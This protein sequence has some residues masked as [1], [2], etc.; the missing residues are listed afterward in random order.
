MDLLHGLLFFGLLIIGNFAGVRSTWFYAIIGIGGVWLAFFFSGV[1][2]TIAGI[3]TAVAIPGRVKIK[4]GTFLKRLD[5]LHKRFQESKS[6]KGTL[7]SNQQLEILEDIKTTS[8][9]AETPLQ[10][11]ERALHPLVSFIILPLFALANAG[12]HLHGD[13]L[14]VL[15]GPVGLGIGL[16]L[17]FGKFI[18]IAA[19]S[20]ILVAL[21]LAKLPENVSWNMIYGT[22]F[23]GGIGF[24]MSL[25]INELAFSDESL[26]F[27]AKV[28]ILFASL[29]SGIVGAILLHKNSKKL[30]TIK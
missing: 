14:K 22:A 1:H 23:L 6:I 20:R 18:G 7:I 5:A 2:P 30:I 25:F 12:I 4:E 13:L 16:G 21:K 17:I 27:A 19:F 26:I 9:E 24:T 10:K 3:L 11:L 8:S 28:S 29:I 15:T